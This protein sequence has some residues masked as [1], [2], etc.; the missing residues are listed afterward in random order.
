MNQE[1]RIASNRPT[2][3][4]VTATNGAPS[5]L[6]TPIPS[7]NIDPIDFA[8]HLWALRLWILSALLCVVFAIANFLLH[9][10]V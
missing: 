3:P 10:W 1:N 8:N 9:Q 7:S 4:V 2:A 5:G 6:P